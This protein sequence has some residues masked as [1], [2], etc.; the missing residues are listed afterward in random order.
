MK[1]VIYTLN[2]II[3]KQLGKK[4]REVDSLVYII[5]LKTALDTVD[6]E[7]MIEAMRKNG[8]REGLVKRTE[9]MFRETKS[10]VRE[11]EKIGEEFWTARGVRQGYPLAHCFLVF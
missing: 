9:E 1:R 6:R 3:N 10:R 2:Y 4:G 5:D 11:G 7:V 8:I